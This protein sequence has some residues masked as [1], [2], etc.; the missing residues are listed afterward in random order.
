MINGQIF[1]H[2]LLFQKY[3]FH[4]ISLSAAGCKRGQYACQKRAVARTEIREFQEKVIRETEEKA[5]KAEERAKEMQDFV[6]K[7]MEIDKC[8][9]LIE[10][11]FLCTIPERHLRVLV[12][13]YL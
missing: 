8:N 1:V 9:P 5:R 2:D 3:G 12:K 10:P 4:L 11:D 7:L 6:D 13:S